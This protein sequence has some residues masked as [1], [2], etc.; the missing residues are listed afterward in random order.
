MDT[1]QKERSRAQ[2]ERQQLSIIVQ[3]GQ[4]LA[5]LHQHGLC[6]GNLMPQAVFFSEPDLVFLGEFRLPAVLA[7]L[8]S[9]QPALEEGMPLCWYLAPE[10]FSGRFHA[11]TDQYALGCLAYHLLTGRLPFS[12]SARAT[13]L[14][15][16]LQEQ[17]CA[18]REHNPDLPVRSTSN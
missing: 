3:V 15:R 12:G 7:C 14:Q 16:H 5:A 8:P 13:L 18:L 4:A 2:K 6:H 11:A 17:P 10:Q 9:Y 1:M